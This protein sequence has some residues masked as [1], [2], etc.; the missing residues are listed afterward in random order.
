[1]M[2]RIG[3]IQPLI[4]D[5]RSKISANESE[6]T[7]KLLDD[8]EDLLQLFYQ[9]NEMINRIWDFH[10]NEKY[11][12]AQETLDPLEQIL[13]SSLLGI[14]TLDHEAKSDSAKNYLASLKKEIEKQLNHLKE[15]SISVY[16]LC[17]QDLGSYGAIKSYYELFKEGKNI[18]I[19]IDFKGTLKR[20]PHKVEIHIFRFIQHLIQ[21]IDNLNTVVT[22][23]ITINEKDGRIVI[24]FEGEALVERL[25]H[26]SN[27]QL[28]KELID[29]IEDV[30]ILEK[31]ES[32]FN[33]VLQTIR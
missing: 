27:Y 29:S 15:A 28:F 32:T 20:Q 21:I 7:I 33:L 26:S 9:K 31:N 16:P 14:R 5:Y 11:Q 25:N 24:T 3:D 2:N 8:Y 22:L 4:Q 18:T 19:D 17:M 13:Y 1:M 10:E 12:L 30:E 23:S 6:L